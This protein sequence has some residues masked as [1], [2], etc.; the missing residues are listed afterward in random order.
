MTNRSENDVKKSHEETKKEVE[1][2]IPPPTNE[3]KRVEDALWID[4]GG[5]G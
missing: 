2:P 5:E 1:I 4:H 3:E